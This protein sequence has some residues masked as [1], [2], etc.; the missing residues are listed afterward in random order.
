MPS[1]TLNLHF[2]LE[3]ALGATNFY[4]P[5][6]AAAMPPGVRICGMLQ[7]NLMSRFPDFGIKFSADTL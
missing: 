6:I 3:N 4:K 2:G 1:G 7:R 5:A